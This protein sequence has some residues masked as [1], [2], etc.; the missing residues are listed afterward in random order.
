MA[1]DSTLGH[2]KRVVVMPSSGGGGGG[3]VGGVEV[4]GIGVGL[5]IETVPLPSAVSNAESQEILEV[6]QLIAYYTSHL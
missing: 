5:N 2:Q 4:G 3:G 6:S 1:R